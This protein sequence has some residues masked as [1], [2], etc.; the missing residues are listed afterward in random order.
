M[1]MLSEER[2]V[3]S[4]SMRLA[5]AAVAGPM[6]LTVPDMAAIGAAGTVPSAT[7]QALAGEV[8]PATSGTQQPA[9]TPQIHVHPRPEQPLAV[10]LAVGGTPES[11]VRAGTLG[12]PTFALPGATGKTPTALICQPIS[13]SRCGVM[14]RLAALYSR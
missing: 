3:K 9:G 1:G 2:L 7:V 13:A 4:A 14:S 12:L 10:W 6:M 5:A 8:A 11:V